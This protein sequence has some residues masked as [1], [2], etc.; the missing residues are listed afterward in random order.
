MR[1]AQAEL[2]IRF[3]QDGDTPEVISLWSLCFPGDWVFQEYFFKN[4]YDPSNN[5]L[6]F[7]GDRLCAMTQML[8]YRMQT[9][10]RTEEVTYIY[11]ACTH[12]NFRRQHLM[13]TLLHR[14]FEIDRQM[15]RAASVL[16]PQE[17]WLFDFYAQFG[18]APV[19]AASHHLYSA[20]PEAEPCVLR[21]ATVYDLSGMDAL[22]HAQM[23]DGAY[24]CRDAV[25]W[26]KQ[27]AMFTHCGGDVLCTG[28]N[29]APMGYAFVWHTDGQLWAQELVC[30][31]GTERGFVRA[32][33]ER[34]CKTECHVTGLGFSKRQPLGCVLR[35]DGARPADGYIN[36]MLN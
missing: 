3:A 29:E 36:L 19:M 7:L 20:L 11:G 5:L 13:D 33:M 6:L 9:G 14:S 27:L 34:C 21:P 35:H 1:Y 4:L 32:L 17:E 28:P 15:G 22:Y 16:I 24:F 8:P 31:P 26:R 25:E 12:P 23:W 18:Y 30:A 2:N 10:C